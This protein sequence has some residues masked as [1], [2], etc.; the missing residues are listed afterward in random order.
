M[1]GRRVGLPVIQADSASEEGKFTGEYGGVGASYVHRKVTGGWYMG[2]RALGISTPTRKKSKLCAGNV[3]HYFWSYRT[4][5][6]HG[7]L[8]YRPCWQRG[9]P[10][11]FR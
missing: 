2:W 4:E 7:I 9:V 6:E 8:G 5:L 1:D 11:Y 3:Q 10:R